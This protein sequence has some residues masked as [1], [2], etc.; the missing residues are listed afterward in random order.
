MISLQCTFSYQWDL[1]GQNR[2]LTE[3][4]YLL[5]LV[6]A[7]HHSFGGLRWILSSLST[8]PRVSLKE[9]IVHRTY[10]YLPLV[11]R[12]KETPGGRDYYRLQRIISA[13][14]AE[15][16][17]HGE[18]FMN[19]KNCSNFEKMPPAPI[20]G[21]PSSFAMRLDQFPCKRRVSMSHQKLAA[22]TSSLNSL[23]G[24]HPLAVLH[25]RMQI[26]LNVTYG[27]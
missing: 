14:H 26:L 19:D 8:G 20:H 22:L 15:P 1:H 25:S 16:L 2:N 24:Y 13:R 17:W 12:N 18:Q 3:S 5:D 23:C 4:Q 21:K 11:T 9:K 10:T 6:S 7:N 27:C